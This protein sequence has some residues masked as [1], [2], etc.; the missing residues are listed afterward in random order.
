[1]FH[2]I[3]FLITGLVAGLLARALMPGR[4]GLTLLKTTLVGMVGAL[5]AGW[6]GRSLGW[7]GPE[8]GAGF[9]ASTIGA[10][11]VLGIYVAVAK[12]GTVGRITSDRDY[13]RKAA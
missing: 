9:V 5:I 13:P 8:D 10:F 1:M 11:V 7:Y 3:G 6:L 12:K 4:Q 2:F